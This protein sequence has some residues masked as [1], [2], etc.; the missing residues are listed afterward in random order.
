MYTENIVQIFFT[1]VIQGITEFLP[2]SSSGHLFFLNS[3][4]SWEDI[5][6]TLII[7]AHF[8]TL[9]AVTIYFNNDLKKY[10][11][12]GPLEIFKKKKTN[13][14]KFF[15]KIVCSSIPIIIFGFL[16]KLYKIS[17]IYN[18]TTI[19]CS[20]I[21]FSILLLFSDKNK[22][23]KEISNLSY[24]ESF[25]IGLF[26]IFALIPGASRA[27]LCITAARFMG[28]SRISAAKY[29]MFLSVPAI[30]GASF[31]MFINITN[32]NSN[33]IWIE[34]GCVFLL[35]FLFAYFTISFFIKLLKRISF[36]F[37]VIYRIIFAIFCLV[38]FSFS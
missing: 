33:I 3:L 2:I 25:L 17:Y 9:L 22:N 29:S 27:G 15:L 14:Y 38:L 35:S 7:S 26:Q 8:G 12:L 13:N 18:S 36:R 6:L 21:F 37:F 4:F 24:K 5:N 23:D 28:F 30:L 11:L 20:A 31:L 32:T 10:F 34:A 16:A 1:S 19:S